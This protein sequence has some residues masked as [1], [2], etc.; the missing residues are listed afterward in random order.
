MY[1]QSKG[2]EDEMCLVC[3]SNKIKPVWLER[4]EQGEEEQEVRE[5]TSG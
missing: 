2:L 1:R 3:L 5:V 4:S